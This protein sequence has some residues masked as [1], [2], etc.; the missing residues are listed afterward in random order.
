[1]LLT[2]AS[3]LTRGYKG[4]VIDAVA[5]ALSVIDAQ[6]AKDLLAKGARSL[7]PK[8]R[9]A[10][11]TALEQGGRS[12]LA[13]MGALAAETVPQIGAAAAGKP[14]FAP[15]RDSAPA[16]L[17]PES[18]RPVW[19]EPRPPPVGPLQPPAA[20]FV[21]ATKP[22]APIS[23]RA[24]AILGIPAENPRRTTDTGYAVIKHPTPAPKR[25]T[26]GEE[27]PQTLPDD[28]PKVIP[29]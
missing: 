10:C 11:R 20:G 29:E 4:A 24:P 22:P 13:R 23:S 8:L 25:P 17:E 26:D 14:W 27:K 19:P 3:S 6:P 21:G 12:E 5:V 9:S 16:L 1:R 2:K 15:D 18:K 28:A 7:N